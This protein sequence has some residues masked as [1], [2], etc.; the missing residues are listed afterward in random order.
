MSVREAF[1]LRARERG[2][3]MSALC[4]EFGISRKTG[5]KWRA[6]FAEKGVAGLE[7]LSRRPHASPL[8]VSG[9]TVAAVVALRQ[10]HPTWG[11]RKLAGSLSRSR[12]DK[13]LSARTVARILA[14]AGLI[15]QAR[16]RR[17]P[18]PT[19]VLAPQLQPQAP[20]VLWTVDFKG[21]WRTRSGERC[22][23]LTIRDAYSRFVLA[24]DVLASPDMK[25]V[26]AIFERVF[27]QF[28]LPSAILSDGGVPFVAPSSKV[29]LTTLSA[30]WLSLGI[31]H[32]RSRPATPSDNGG[33]ERMHRDM[34]AE[35]EAASALSRKEQQAA[36]DRWRHDFNHHRPHEALKMKTPAEVYK[37]SSV[38]F[39]P[40]P[41]AWVYPERHH[42]RRISPIGTLKHKNIPLFLS[43]AL[44]GYDVGLEYLA[45]DCFAVW[46]THRRLGVINLKAK[47]FDPDPWNHKPP[48]QEEANQGKTAA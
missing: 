33:H 48:K 32:Y 4:E 15:Q 26:R 1:V 35:L 12:G 16:R 40:K 31:E 6:R 8:R 9:D 23:P 29:G 5:Y 45:P 34:A 14:R 21:W 43:T 30:W 38:E 20:N 19:G 39:A 37:R 42:V 36:C 18:A 17:R 44:A 10:A 47:T 27:S 2:A 41:T 28:G 24:I 13:P 3:N 7:D 46:F 22:E 25:E 11:P